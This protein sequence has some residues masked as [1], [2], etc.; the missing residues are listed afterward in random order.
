VLNRSN[1]EIETMRGE[2]NVRQRIKPAFK[3]GAFKIG[4]FKIGAFKI[5]A[6]K[7]IV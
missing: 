2:K 5:G 7:T 1:E 6:F 4:A 3:T